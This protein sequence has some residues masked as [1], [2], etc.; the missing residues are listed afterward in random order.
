MAVETQSAVTTGSD[1]EPP[2]SGRSCLGDIDQVSSAEQRLNEPRGSI[3]TRH[4]VSA[5]YPWVPGGRVAGLCPSAANLERAGTGC[6]L[7]SAESA[8]IL[9]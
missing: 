6:L 2:P 5:Q 8:L 3:D 1:G 9:N 7:Q 4:R